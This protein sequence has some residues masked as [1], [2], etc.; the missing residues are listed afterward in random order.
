MS[1]PT[2]IVEQL[3]KS[4]GHRQVLD[5][6]NFRVTSGE[7]VALIGPSGSGKSTLMRHLV[8][9]TC[10][11]RGRG[12]RVELMGRE[13]QASGRLRRASRGERCRIGYIFQQ[14]NLVGR[15]SVLSNVLIGRLGSMPRAR[16][17]LGRFTEQE[18]QRARAC[19]ARVGLEEMTNQRANT[20][21]GGQMQ[22]V[23]IA[24]VL[25]QDADVILADE[26]IASLDP[27]SAREVMEILSRIHAEDGRTV[28]VTLHQVDVARRY[29]HRAIALKDGRLYFDGAISELTDARL[30]SL[31][32]NAGLDELRAGEALGAHA[33][34]LNRQS[35]TTQP[36]TTPVMA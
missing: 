31:Y 24:R 6:V 5:E 15:L 28:I 22:R 25:M 34:P 1:I 7:M 26:P 18:R 30:Q 35:D 11:N 8:G 2:I 32:E 20:L 21:S 23:A 36:P 13:V 10:G 17:L 33:S 3:H 9:L 19:L 12:G 4:F 14:F 27:R 29:C 16:A